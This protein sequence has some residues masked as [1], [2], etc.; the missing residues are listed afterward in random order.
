MF[1]WQAF[2]FLRPN[3]LYALLPLAIYIYFYFKRK[4]ASSNWEQVC[5]PHLLKHLLITQTQPGSKTP[6]ILLAIAWLIATLALA[7]PTWSKLEQPLFRAQDTLL[8]VMDLSRSMDANDLKPSRLNLAK[9]KVTDLLKNHQEGKTGLIVYA[10]EPYV[11]SPLT[12]DADTILAQLPSLSTA[13]MPAQG[14]R[15]DLA[16]QQAGDLI[17]QAGVPKAHILLISDDLSF[18]VEQAN[19][20]VKDFKQR[21]I[22]TSVLAVGT[23]DGAPISLPQGG[24][25]KDKRGAI[26][27][28][29][30]D[31]QPLQTVAMAG[32]GLYQKITP[33]NQDIQRLTPFFQGQSEFDTV[34]EQKHTTDRWQEQGPWLALLL[35]PI[36]AFAF[37]K[38]WVSV[39]FVAVMLPMHDSHAFEWQDL[40]LTPN[41]Q[42]AKALEQNDHQQA[43][44][45]FSDP[46]W[47]GTALYQQG[48]YEQAAQ[49]FSQLNDA[50]GHY[51]R[52]N[53]L[54]KAGKL[55][56]AL[57]AYDEALK[58]QPE[59]DDAKFNR[60]I[61]ESLLKQQQQQSQQSDSSQQNQQP[62]NQQ[63]DQSS[64]QNQQQNQQG[65]TSQSESQQA[66]TEQSQQQDSQNEQQQANQQNTQEQD[67]P[68]SSE[69]Q[70]AQQDADREAVEEQRQQQAQ[71]DDLTPQQ[72]EAQQAVE[73]WLKRVPDDPGGLLRRKFMREHQKQ[74]R[75]PNAANTEQPW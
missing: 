15:P 31:E 75:N 18:H 50:A 28:P 62:Q 23:T 70:Q 44:E 7:G 30:L 42:A 67:E 69:T 46:G 9:F 25:L 13:L 53:A 58:Q 38:G 43:S 49:A 26:V 5:D 66:N 20:I 6:I 48:D 3:W 55:E 72:Q 56:D 21:H 52:A 40:W 37:R 27:V 16:L 34:D 36:A 45:K 41:Q 57:K 33:G 54:A 65:D 74:R 10:A 64:S 2:H 32:G 1:D 68:P 4:N 12:H 51:N 60:D 17:R 35:L 11:V 39:V 24:F 71:V 63:N 22:T 19:K 47:K 29:Q 73:Q 59:H 8:I 14:S 61:V